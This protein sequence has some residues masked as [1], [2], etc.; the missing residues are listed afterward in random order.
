MASPA[1]FIKKHVND[2]ANDVRREHGVGR[3]EVLHPLELAANLEIPV[4][5]LSTMKGVTDGGAEYLLYEESSALS[6][7]TVFRGLRRWI[8]YN[9]ANSVERQRSDVCHELSHGLL[10][11]EPSPALDG[12]GLRDWDQVMEAEAQFMAGALLLPEPAVIAAV[13]R[14]DSLDRIAAAYGVSI[15]MARWRVNVTGA[16]KRAERGRAKW[17]RTAVRV[18]SSA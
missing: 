5:A 8:V 6:A 7:V 14:G 17:L 3:Y 12:S 2:L 10:L 16:Y 13:R 15:E 1:G 18:D 11:H 4:I 9:D